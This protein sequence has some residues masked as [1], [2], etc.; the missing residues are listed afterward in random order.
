MCGKLIQGVIS[1]PL[2]FGIDTLILTSLICPNLI[3]ILIIN[4]DVRMPHMMLIAKF[5]GVHKRL[6]KNHV[7]LSGGVLS[8]L[9]S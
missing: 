1:L 2:L 4:R 3:N 8:D 6:V 7:S 9:Q 5:L